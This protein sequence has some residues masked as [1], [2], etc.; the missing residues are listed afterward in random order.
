M[1]GGPCWGPLLCEMLKLASVL[2]RFRMVDCCPHWF[3]IASD[4]DK[5][6]S[7]KSLDVSVELQFQGL[8]AYI[9]RALE[10]MAAT[11][12]SGICWHHNI[13]LLLPNSFQ[14]CTAVMFLQHG[15]LSVKRHSIACR[16][17][18]VWL[19]DVL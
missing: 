5:C 1:M 6:D 4:C 18:L 7:P 16:L 11:Q 9:I 10:A 12:H 15:K 3:S 14:W 13:L 8:P 2:L 17:V 19:R